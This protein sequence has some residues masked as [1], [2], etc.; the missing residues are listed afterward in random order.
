M[1]DAIHLKPYKTLG[2]EVEDNFKANNVTVSS[3]ILVQLY[4]KDFFIS[5][6]VCTFT[7][8]FIMEAHVMVSKSINRYLNT[9]SIIKEFE[10]T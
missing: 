9:F 7:K 5:S 2:H 8:Q 3:F 10:L 6:L 4:K 1:L